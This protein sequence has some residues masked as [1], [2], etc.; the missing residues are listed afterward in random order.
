[1]KVNYQEGQEVLALWKK[2]SKSFPQLLHLAIALL[3]IPASS[4][5]SERIFS[6]TGQILEARRQQLNSD[7]LNSLYG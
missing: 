3:L 2:H 1:M 7:S 5:A 6:E 4:N